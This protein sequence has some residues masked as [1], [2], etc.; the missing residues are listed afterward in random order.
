MNEL[1]V[2]IRVPREAGAAIL[3]SIKPELDLDTHGRSAVELT[4][5]R[6]LTLHI[7]AKDLH[8]LR[9]ATNTYLR[10]LDMCLKLTK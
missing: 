2:R 5:D 6:E 7:T 9:A 1:T 3:D 10:W 4:Y 8:A